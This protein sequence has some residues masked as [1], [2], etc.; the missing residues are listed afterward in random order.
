ML[1][2]LGVQCLVEGHPSAGPE[3]DNLLTQLVLRNSAQ[4]W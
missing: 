4:A 1:P 2:G 3:A